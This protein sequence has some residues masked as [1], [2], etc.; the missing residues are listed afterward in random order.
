[1]IRSVNTMI[2]AVVCALL[3]VGCQS[4]RGEAS[5][6]SLGVPETI[7]EPSSDVTYFVNVQNAGGTVLTKV[8]VEI[9]ADKELSDLVAAGKTDDD[10]V[11]QFVGSSTAQYHAV[12]SKLPVGY[13]P[14][15]SYPL[16]RGSTVVCPDIGV[17]SDTDMDSVRYTLG[18]AILDY[19]F[20][21]G[22]G[23]E[24]TI[25]QILKEKKAVLLNFWF[26]N[27][28]PCKAEFSHLQEAYDAYS[29]VIE[30]LALNPLDSDPA[31]ISAFRQENGFTFPMMKCD[32]RWG[33]VFGITGYPLS[34]LIDR[35]GNIALTHSGSIP[36]PQ[37]FI[38]A[39][40]HYSADDYEQTFFRSVNLLPT[41]EM[42]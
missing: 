42:P 27:C 10:G 5:T 40:A 30:V 28:D 6:G 16:S 17:M 7:S 11:F 39:F 23:N 20:V 3:L 33:S 38:N 2:L 9:Y 1:M 34:V 35:Y 12:L 14:K 25:S 26:M 4:D 36:D 41:V 18:D 24:Y 37:L 29:D 13:V 8:N 15:E 21:D 22:E 31:S 32:D 19:T